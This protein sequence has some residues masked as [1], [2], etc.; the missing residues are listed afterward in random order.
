M[1]HLLSRKVVRNA[2]L[3]HKCRAGVAQRMKVGI[4]ALLIPVGNANPLRIH[5]EPGGARNPMTKHQIRRRPV[6]RTILFQ[7]P[8][9][10]RHQI[11]RLLSFVLCRFRTNNDQRVLRVKPDIAPLKLFQFFLTQSRC[12]RRE[13]DYP[14]RP[15]PRDQLAQLLIREGPAHPFL[16][17]ALIHLADKFQRIGLDPPRPLHPVEERNRTLQIM[18]QCPRRRLLLV[19]PGDE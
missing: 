6:R 16:F 3:A 13:I 19:A 14:A 4:A 12:C 1:T 9:N 18:I 8:G 11:N 5:F 2:V 15:R 10:F 7:C 17:P